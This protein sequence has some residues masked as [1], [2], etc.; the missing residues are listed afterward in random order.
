MPS[1]RGRGPEGTHRVY[2]IGNDAPVSVNALLAILERLTGRTAL[3]VDKPMQPGDVRATHADISALRRDFGFSPTTRLEDGLAAF[4]AWYR[5]WN[6][7]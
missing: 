5:A 6:G 4:V 7:L 2:N 1:R 3:R